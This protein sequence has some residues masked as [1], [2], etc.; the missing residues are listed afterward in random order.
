VCREKTCHSVN[1]TPQKAKEDGCLVIV[2]GGE[3]VPEKEVFGENQ[4]R[5]FIDNSGNNAGKQFLIR[6][7]IV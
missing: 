3:G 7:Y 6:L 5:Q 1:Y 2:T 4:W